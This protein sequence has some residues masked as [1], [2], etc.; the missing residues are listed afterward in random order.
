MIRRKRNPSQYDKVKALAERGSTEHERATAARILAGMTSPAQAARSAVDTARAARAQQYAHDAALLRT[1]REGDVVEV[2]FAARSSTS[3]DERRKLTVQGHDALHDYYVYVSSGKVL[4]GHVSG[5]AIMDYGDVIYYQPTM[6][7]PLRVVRSL[8]R[9]GGPGQALKN[10]KHPRKRNPYPYGPEEGRVSLG[11]LQSGLTLAKG[12]VYWITADGQWYSSSRLLPNQVYA[13]YDD[14][15]P[16]ALGYAATLAQAKQVLGEA[17][18]EEGRRVKSWSRSGTKLVHKNPIHPSAG[19]VP[20]VWPEGWYMRAEPR[21]LRKVQDAIRA[22]DAARTRPE[23][24]NA[25]AAACRVVREVGPTVDP[26]VTNSVGWS[27]TERLKQLPMTQEEQEQAARDAVYAANRKKGARRNPRK[28]QLR[29]G[30]VSTSYGPYAHGSMWQL[31]GDAS[32]DIPSTI[33]VKYKG[34][35]FFTTTYNRIGAAEFNRMLRE[36]DKARYV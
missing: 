33:R 14:S 23:L 19:T 16:K 35:Q 10:P 5:G 36:W 32:E 15:A 21:A 18:R 31:S 20:E 30:P 11:K 22:I 17:R 12:D 4:R 8:K 28:K 26:S 29:T 1:L 6:Q 2:V 24:Y 7:Q 3:P 13:L 25:H 9:V 27:Y 34:G